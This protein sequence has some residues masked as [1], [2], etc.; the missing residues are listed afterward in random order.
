MAALAL[1]LEGDVLAAQRG[2]REAFTRLVDAT[3]N[4]VCSIVVA[5]VRDIDASEDVAQEVFLATWHGIRRLRKAASFLPWL[6]QLAR[7]QAHASLRAQRRQ[8]RRIEYAATDAV[9]ARAADPSPP[10]SEHLVSAEEKQVLT[11]VIDG[12]PEDAREVVTLYYRE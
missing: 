8:R 9:L 12:L 4:L 7:N 5:I 1:K 2:D 6:R 11:T 10:A 3:R